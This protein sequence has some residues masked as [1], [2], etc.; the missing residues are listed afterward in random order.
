MIQFTW[1]CGFLLLPF[2]IV[3]FYFIFTIS[4]YVYTEECDYFCV[5]VCMC[6]CTYA[7][8]CGRQRWILDAFMFYILFLRQGLPSNPV[9]ADSAGLWLTKPQSSTS[10]FHFPITGN[11]GGGLHCLL[12]YGNTSFLSQ[13]VRT[14]NISCSFCTTVCSFL[15]LMY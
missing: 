9:L 3:A 12:S 10:C 5:Y 4:A 14:L 2:L 1:G 6:V 11:T 13:H 7:C 15:S 8:C